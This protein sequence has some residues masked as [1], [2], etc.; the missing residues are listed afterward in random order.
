MKVLITGAASKL[1]EKLIESLGESGVEIVALV[2]EKRINAPGAKVTPVS[3]DLLDLAGLENA[4][5]NIDLVVHLAALTH[6]RRPA[7][8]FKVNVI[9]TKNVISACQKNKVPRLIFVS[10]RAI[11][12]KAGAYG[13]SKYLAEQAVVTSGL[14]WL[15]FR[16]SEIYGL[17][18][19]EGID[20][21]INLAQNSFLMPILGRG[22][23]ALNPV[24]FQDVIKV[25]VMAITKPKFA[26]KLYTVCG[27]KDYSY[28]ELTVLL[29]N[30]F[31]KKKI[32]I[33]LP[34][35]ALKLLSWFGF[36]FQDQ[37]PRLLAA[38]S[39]D[40]SAL[41]KD[42][43]FQPVSIAEYLNRQYGSFSQL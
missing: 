23:Y 16:P 1:G 30:H 34:V 14:E 7:D 41:V 21:L 2:H 31:R 3:A 29:A 15:I 4:F 26:N 24:Y 38:K 5:K 9:G 25:L 17:N 11:G 18:G 20:R 12:E 22:Q 36:F 19:K 37:V 27:P 6:A 8:Y 10:T 13:Q 32:F 35:G 33:P 40:I 39:S 28:K 43:E 42:Y